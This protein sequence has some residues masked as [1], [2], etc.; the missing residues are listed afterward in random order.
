M[1]PTSS[2]SGDIAT[3]LHGSSRNTLDLDISFAVDPQNLEA[4]GEVLLALS[5]RL[6]GVPEDVSFVPDAAPCAG[7]RS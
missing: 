3:V 7:W 6:R 4:L 2:S 5:A 1:G